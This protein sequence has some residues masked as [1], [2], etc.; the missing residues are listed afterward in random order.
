MLSSSARLCRARLV[1]A[2]FRDDLTDPDRCAPV[3]KDVE[4]LS[5]LNTALM[6]AKSDR[7]GTNVL[8]I[9]T[10]GA[11]PPYTHLLGGKLVALLLMSPEV[12]DDYRRRY[13]DRPAII[14]SQLKNVERSKDCTLAWLNTT[15]LYSVGS[16]QYERV[17]LPAGVI[18][19][20]QPELRYKHLGDTEGYGTVQFSDKTVLALQAAIEERHQFR[21]VNSIFGEGF[22]P[23]F[24]KLVDGMALLGFNPSVLMR[25]DQRRRVYAVSMW[26]G[27][28]A[29]LRG[30]PTEQPSYIQQPR[31]FRTASERI[32][33]LTGVADG[34]S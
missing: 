29:F 23:K 25:H 21:G 22:S 2:K 14:S 26:N 7:V 9:T 10:C 4:L 27:A 20:D 32:A 34:N 13:S 11:I 16:S 19:P 5:A 12:A 31:R 24:R 6:S 33:D 15:S 3:L 28:D 1:L 18:A 8:E 30:E 17:R